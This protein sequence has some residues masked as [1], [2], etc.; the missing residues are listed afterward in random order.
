MC[1][2]TVDIYSITRRSINVISLRA[3]LGVL[4]L[5][6]NLPVCSLAGV[7]GKNDGNW[8]PGIRSGRA[9]VATSTAPGRG[10]HLVMQVRGSG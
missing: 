5:V 9:P 4:L 8:Q 2:T 3:L 10:R 7:P 6:A 1:R